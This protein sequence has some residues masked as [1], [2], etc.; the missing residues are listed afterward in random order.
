MR[1]GASVVARMSRRPLAGRQNLSS[2]VVATTQQQRAFSNAATATVSV[3]AQ[4]LQKGLTSEI[5]FEKENYEKPEPLTKLPADWKFVDTPGDVN[6]V[7]EK[8]LAGGNKICKIEWQLVAPFDPE[9]DDFENQDG[10]TGAEGQMPEQQ[11]E[12]DFTI[13]CQTK[14]GESGLTLFCNTQQGE[15]HRFII[16]NVKTWN[17]ASERDSPSAYNGP[18]FDDLET[19]LQ[20]AMDEY[21]AEIG[22]NDAIYDF[23]DAAAVDKETREYMR[24][25]ENLNK[26]I[27]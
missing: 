25:L 27:Q 26:F 10:A 6:M 11:E 3:A 21:L 12:T 9:M 4:K 5:Q 23:I 24:W 2:A 19:K 7:L 8:E 15:S 18:D 22:V 13:T 14:D 20:E 16:G 17:N 1:S